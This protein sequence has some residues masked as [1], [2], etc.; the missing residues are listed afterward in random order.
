MISKAFDWSVGYTKAPGCD[1][2]EWYPATVPG[3][4][5]LDYA[6]A[7]Q[8]HP[9][10]YGVNFQ[11]YAWMEDV[12]WCYRTQLDFSLDANQTACVRF[13]GIDYRYQIR[14]DGAV[15]ADGEGMFTPVTCEVSRYA[16]QPHIL[17]VLI[18]PAPK[19][20]DSNTRD[21]ARKSCKPAACYGWD[22][23]PRLI[24][25]GLFDKVE[26][27]IQDARHIKRM[28]VSYQLSDSLARCDVDATLE[29]PCDAQVLLQLLDGDTVVAEEKRSCTVGQ[30]EFSF[31]VDSPKL[32][33]PVGY[34]EHPV[35]TLRGATLDEQGN[36]V[37]ETVRRI[38]F[39]RSR[40]VMNEG[41]WKE[42][43]QFPKSRSDAPATLEI[44]GRRIFAKGSN[45][46]NA[47]IFPG[48]VTDADYDRLVTLAQ[49]ANM[50]ILRIWG[51]GFVNHEAFFD[52]CDEKGI[53]VWQEF[54][55]ACNE[56]PDEDGYLSVLEQEATS[57]VRRLRSHPCVV[58]W[59]G[60]NELF[61]S[62][63]KMTEQ[64]HALRLL[65]KVCYTE[66]RFTP[67]I[68]TSPLN[69]MA[70][71]HYFNYDESKH[72]EFIS[73]IVRSNNTAYTEFGGPG[74]AAT[75]Y[76][77]QYLS[78]ADYA[79]CDK[80]NEAWCAHHAFGAWQ[81]ESWLRK[82]EV[83]H[84]FGGYDDVDDLCEKT[85]FIQSMCYRSY[86]EEMRKQ[87][88]HCSMALNWCFNE[89]WPSFANNSLLSWPDIPKPGYYAVQAALRPQLASLRIDRHLWW[90]GET[91]RAEVWLLNDGLEEL[92]S[93][94]VEVS[95]SVDGGEPVRWGT[96]HAAKV[97][98][99]RNLLCGG[100]SFA[101]PVSGYGKIRIWLKVPGRPEMDSEYTYLFRE[102]KIVST[103]GMLNM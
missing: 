15:I 32:W 6:K 18:Y 91:F 75:D 100:V 95:Y 53:M 56:Y 59:C 81:K 87:W 26:L 16:D 33:Y 51:G 21:Q 77:K 57:I 69:G 5:Q 54:P 39:R 13:G 2:Q 52:L 20:D 82:P 96:L 31:T 70:H 99:Q 68:M 64:H 48:A 83:D 46:V 3:A 89:P 37:K 43:G 79:D 1:P 7:K 71:G 94:D 78:A 50:N 11:D 41:S 42:P 58:L 66:D 10:E 103:K 85:R 88:P 25:A 86:F 98:A 14:M 102:K 40:M 80:D 27:L 93:L 35:Y 84:Y 34:G 47:D 62:W 29:L 38:G 101:V 97:E 8:W 23:H 65:D 90:A 24:S 55:L 74:A 45:W 19:A 61:N 4:V 73:L 17:E 44:N 67:F 92:S 28:D 60:G 49:Q 72:E 76:I 12:F 22:W 9:Y 30:A 36:T 63:S